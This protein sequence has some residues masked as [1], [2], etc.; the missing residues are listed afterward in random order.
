MDRLNMDLY[1]NEPLTTSIGLDG[2][3]NIVVQAS[4]IADLSV[5]I[6]LNAS[7]TQILNRE[8]YDLVHD[9]QFGETYDFAC[10]LVYQSR[11]RH[12]LYMFVSFAVIAFGCIGN[13]INALVY[14][15]WKEQFTSANVYFLFLSIIDMLFLVT[16]F[17]SRGLTNL[18][19][20]YF[21]DMHFDIVNRST[22][23]CKLLQYLLDNLSNASTVIVLCLTI[24]RVIACYRPMRFRSLCTTKR[25]SKTSI[26]LI[27]FIFSVTATYHFMSIGRPD[28]LD[29]C[30]ILPS[31]EKVFYGTYMAEMVA[32]K[33]MPVLAIAFC[34]LLI[35]LNERERGRNL[36]HPTISTVDSRNKERDSNSNGDRE[37]LNSMSAIR[38]LVQQKIHKDKCS[39]Q[40]GGQHVR[41]RKDKHIIVVL[42]CISISYMICFIPMSLHFLLNIL[43]HAGMVTLSPDAMNTFK[44]F[45]N[46]LYIMGFSLN[47]FLYTLS[48]PLF[49]SRLFSMLRCRKEAAG[50]DENRLEECETA[51]L[52]RST[53]NSPMVPYTPSPKRSGRRSAMRIFKWGRGKNERSDRTSVTVSTDIH[54]GVELE[55]LPSC[56]TDKRSFDT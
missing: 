45:S 8:D 55:P 3:S 23:A 19:C 33:V 10:H 32:F 7:R 27:I 18:R 51:F 17:L 5:A 42:F 52:E 49:R 35:G 43:K 22:I 1:A 40:K 6:Q 39:R 56:E 9:G 36:R 30:T 53:P 41:D 26:T 54:V 47:L 50:A 38:F 34:N 37:R 16:V 14:A 11:G 20:L 48:S 46:L 25:A 28:G 13:V 2:A 21:P 24:E 12:T 31:Y 15:S 29:V 4:D 44:I